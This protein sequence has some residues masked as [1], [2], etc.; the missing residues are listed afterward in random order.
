[1]RNVAKIKVFLIIYLSIFLNIVLSMRQCQYIETIN[2][3]I[4]IIIN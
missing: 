2:N 1:M 4:I 3:I